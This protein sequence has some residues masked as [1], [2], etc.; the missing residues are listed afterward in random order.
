MMTK[1]RFAL[2]SV[3]ALTALGCATTPLQDVRNFGKAS[4]SFASDGAK[5]FTILTDSLAEYDLSQAAADPSINLQADTFKGSNDEQSIRVSAGKLSAILSNVTEYGQALQGLAEADFKKSTDESATKLNDSL[6]GLKTTFEKDTGSK[7][8]ISSSDI[9]ILSTAVEGIG[10]LVAEA[11][12]KHAIKLVVTKTDAAIQQVSRRLSL[13]FKKDI[14]PAVETYMNTT[15]GEMYKDF[16]VNWKGKTYPE[17][18][19]REDQIRKQE[20]VKQGIQPFFDRLSKSAAQ[21]GQAHAALAAAVQKDAF[22]T[23]ELHAQVTALVD[24][25]KSVKQF[26]DSLNKDTNK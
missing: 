13:R 6:Q 16:N 24:Y 23:A 8:S 10:V 3:T 4:S 11:K 15:L 7:L 9:Q 12:R 19:D 20:M 17:R 1:L 21:M 2:V 18:Q 14:G 25:A 26:Y 5:G 22:S